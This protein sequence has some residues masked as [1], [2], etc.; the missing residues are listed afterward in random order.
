MDNEILEKWL[1]V[2]E[3]EDIYEV[4]DL[5]RVRR[6]PFYGVTKSGKKHF[7]KGLILKQEIKGRCFITLRQQDKQERFCV[8]KLVLKTFYN[9]ESINNYKW[10]DNNNKNNKLSNL[11]II[12][13][14]VKTCKN[15]NKDKLL[16][17]FYI[18]D[19]KTSTYCKNC[20]IIK[21]SESQQNN[22]SFR[23]E[24]LKEYGKNNKNKILEK[25]RVYREENREY[26]KDYHRQYQVKRRKE[27]DLFRI[28]HNIRNRLWDAFKNKNWKKEGSERLLGATYET[29]KIHIES[30]FTEGMSWDN[31]GRCEEGDCTNFWHI[32][33]IIP[34]N[35]ATTKEELENLCNYSNLQPLWAIDNLSKPKT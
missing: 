28:K 25:R 13:E 31:Y 29:V 24:Y 18:Y 34:L 6:L 19:G 11:C 32:D 2:K 8:A 23:K 7:Y 15:C 33:H 16:D 17:N 22:K 27:H 10:I 21:S 1:P 5:G 14:N 26:F 9:T 3:W 4:S 20:T 30:L 12:D 35:T